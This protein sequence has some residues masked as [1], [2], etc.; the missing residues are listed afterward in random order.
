MENK[1]EIIKH[2]KRRVAKFFF[3]KA[4]IPLYN[5]TDDV[6]DTFSTPV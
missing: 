4:V 5:I 3:N 1:Q 6:G 2:G